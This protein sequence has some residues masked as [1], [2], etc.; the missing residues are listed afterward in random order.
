MFEIEYEFGEEDLIH[1]N[2]AR[3]MKTDEYKNDI[4][5]N[6]LIV[7][8]VLGPNERVFIISIIKISIPPVISQLLLLSGPYLS[9][10]RLY[11]AGSVGIS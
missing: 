1:F 7:P 6:R 2:K 4:R 9:P 3:Y 8:G 10:E 11:H 5:T